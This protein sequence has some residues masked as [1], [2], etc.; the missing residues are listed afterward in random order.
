MKF[1]SLAKIRLGV[2]GVL[3]IAIFAGFLVYPIAFDRPMDWL[4]SKLGLALP[5]YWQLPFHLGLDLQGGTHLVYKADISQVPEA[6]INDA[7]AGVR[8]VIERRINVFGVAEPVVQTGKSGDQWQVIVELAGVKDVNQAIKMI[9]ETPLLEFKEQADPSTQTLTADEQ[10]QLDEFNAAAK[11]KA[12]DILKE[13]LKTPLVQFGDLAEKYSE[14]GSA[15]GGGSLDWAK[16]GIFVAE[17]EQAAFALKKGQVTKQLV[18]TQFGYHIIYKED[19]RG[20]GDSQ[21]VKASHI[22]I[23]TKTAAEFKPQEQFVYTGLTGKQLKRSQVQFDPNT[24]VPEVSLEFNDEGKD[25]FAEIT[26]K[27]VNK[28][29]GIFLDGE[30]I[31]LPKVNEPILDGKAVI[32]GSFT[33]PEAKLLA[34]RLNAGALPVPI[35]LIAQQTVGATL[36]NDS[37]QKSLFAGLLGLLAVVVFMLLYYRLPGLLSVI[38]LLIYSVLA[39]TIFKIF[40][41]TLTL[42]GIA[43]F[44]LS[45]GIA[46]DANVLVFERLKEEFRAGRPLSSAID[47]A[48][49]RA[50]PSIRDGNASTLITCIILFWFTSSMVK[51]FALTLSIGILVSIFTAMVVTRGLLKT[52][53][54]GRVQN[55]YFLFNRKKVVEQKPQS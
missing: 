18:K 26:K 5:H 17:F 10:K 21:E 32:S 38:A 34:Q 9:G 52:I 40:G 14:D 49:K 28:I 54:V 36:G 19:E 8:D 20:E 23:K 35:E 2:L 48:F 6:D 15:A 11:K 47:E 4:N 53:A 24:Q 46:V 16:Q 3:I 25:L 50:W 12:E 39:L 51:G 44:I 45:L 13:V 31:S 27:N 1:S 29:V 33:L 7:V 43:G 30:P 37:V 42:A 22:L 41:I 55:W